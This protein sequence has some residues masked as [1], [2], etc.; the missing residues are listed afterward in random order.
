MGIFYKVAIYGLIPHFRNKWRTNPEYIVLKTNDVF[1]MVFRVINNDA[2]K[3]TDK[4]TLFRKTFTDIRK[5]LKNGVGFKSFTSIITSKDVGLLKDFN[6]AIRGGTNYTKAFD[7][8]LSKVPI[9]IKRQG[10]EL[11]QLNNQVLKLNNSYKNGKITQQ[12]YNAQMNVLN[13]RV[14]NVIQ[15]TKTLT[16]SER[17]AT[18]VTKGLGV[19]LK[20][21]FNIGLGIAINLIVTAIYKLINA[22]KEYNEKTKELA[23]NIHQEKEEI[24]GLY[25]QYVNISEEYTVDKSKKEDLIK[26]TDDLLEK[27]GHE[28]TTIQELVDEYGNLDNAIQNIT[29]ENL[30]EKRG[31]LSNAKDV[32]ENELKDK[33]K[34]IDKNLINNYENYIRANIGWNK[35]WDDIGGDFIEEYRKWYQKSFSVENAEEFIKDTNEFISRLEDSYYQNDLKKIRIYSALVTSRD[36]LKESLDEYN[37]SVDNVNKNEAEM[38]IA[39]AKINVEVPKTQG[40]FNSFKNS[41]I[42]TVLASDDMK[43]HFVGDEKEVERAITNALKE[44]PEYTKFF[45]HDLLDSTGKNT[46]AVKKLTDTYEELS[47]VLDDL[48]SKQDKLAGLYEKIAKSTELS[49]SEARELIELFPELTSHLVRIGSKWSFDIKGVNE[50]FDKLEDEFTEKAQE[51]IDNNKKIIEQSFED[52]YAENTK[53]NLDDYLEENGVDTSDTDSLDYRTA[54]LEYDNAL[55]EERNKLLEAYENRQAEANAEIEK[56]IAFQQ[57]LNNQIN[58][59]DFDVDNYNDKIKELM[60][61]S[62]KMAESEALSYDELTSLIDKFPELTYSG[63]NGE[64]FIEKTAL[65]ELITKSYEERNAR[66]DDEIA[67]TYAV[68]EEV[69]NRVKA[70]ED[71]K[72]R[73]ENAIEENRKKYDESYNNPDLTDGILERIELNAEQTKL[74]NELNDLNKEQY[75]ADKALMESQDKY[76]EAYRKYLEALKGELTGKSK[77]KEVA[78]ELQNQIDYYKTIISAIEI[79]CDKYSEAFEKEKEALENEKK[80]LQ[81]SKDALKDANNERQRELDLIEA[82]NNL[83]NAKKRKVWVYS[84]GSGFKQ[85]QDEKAVKE[86]EEKYRDA[87]TDIQEA[88]ID[89]KIAEID[90]KIEANEKQQEAFEKSLEDMTELEQNIEDAKTVEQA[91]SALGLADEKD[92]LNLSDAIKEGIKNGLADAIVKKDNE[93]NKDK[94]DANGNSLY[95]PVSLNDV[96]KSMGASVTAE[97][98]K[99][100]KNELP[101]KSAYDAMVKGFTDSL[102]EFTDNAVNSSVVNNNGGTVI[103]PT[104]I[105]NDA[106]DP[107]KIAKVVNAEITNLFTKVG[108]SIK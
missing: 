97:D 104:I 38:A 90:Q 65:D 57:L 37:A 58:D 88:A 53:L 22:Q 33:Y 12:E 28:K 62:E 3:L 71:E 14:N 32:A 76:N 41:I 23:K 61:A 100:I 105:I 64:Y 11:I 16:V 40:E 39:L 43:K 85:V 74:I 42:D 82:R 49:A 83:E 24:K 7:T 56:A 68:N 5:D 54:L 92:L 101:T 108:N 15:S 102:K 17:I 50:A 20:L 19:A 9:S 25:K 87:I 67:K 2:T 78:N 69:A 72:T 21:A 80:A 1:K 10:N 91:K 18:G 86:A 13:G 103:S 55:A 84:E 4:L 63:N 31:T 52:Y 45:S 66:I 99:S 29:Y 81:D 60:D 94:V 34:S 6:N 27:L 79:M 95:T 73:I 70:Y 47:E 46:L 75:E 96:L 30:K 8:Y 59:F 93:E 89:K 35:F 77:D 26:I 36:D 44:M 98:L 48:F 107:D 106:T 51:T